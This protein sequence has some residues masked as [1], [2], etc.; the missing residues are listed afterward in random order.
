MAERGRGRGGAHVDPR[1]EAEDYRRGRGGYAERGG[2]DRGRGGGA[3]VEP[4]AQLHIETI[5][6]TQLP[7]QKVDAVIPHLFGGLRSQAEKATRP[8]TAEEAAARRK[9]RDSDAQGTETAMRDVQA[10]ASDGARNVKIPTNYFP[11][12]CSLKTSFMVYDVVVEPEIVNPRARREIVKALVAR[13]ATA[14]NVPSGIYRN[15]IMYAPRSLHP[16]NTKSVEIVHH[17]QEGAKGWKGKAVKVKLTHTRDIAATKEGLSTEY[18]NVI[19]SILAEALEEGGLMKII[20]AYYDINSQFTAAGG[21][22]QSDQYGTLQLMKGYEFALHPTKHGLM[23]NVDMTFRTTRSCTVLDHIKKIMTLEKDPKKAQKLVAEE[24]EGCIGLTTYQHERR[25]QTFKITQVLFDKTPLS[26][27]PKMTPP[28]TFKEY[29][30]SAHQIQLTDD[31]QPLLRHVSK[32][33]VDQD[34]KPREFFFIPELSRLV[35]Q[36]TRMRADADLQQELKRHCLV[37]SCTRFNVIFDFVKNFF[38]AKPVRDFLNI[39]GIVITPKM[40]LAPARVLPKVQLQIQGDRPLEQNEAR[41]SWLIRKGIRPTEL[42]AKPS[43]WAYVFPMNLKEAAQQ[44]LEVLMSDTINGVG[45]AWSA[46]TEYP[47]QSSPNPTQNL[48]TLKDRILPEIDEQTKFM[49]IVLPDDNEEFYVEVKRTSLQEW[50]IPSQCVLRKNVLNTRNHQNVASRIGGQMLV[51]AGGHLWHAAA[52]QPGVPADPSEC[53]VCGIDYATSTK[54]E[55]VALSAMAAPK[56]LCV[57][58]FSA[59]A[60]GGAVGALLR[61]AIDAYTGQF[62]KPPK[63][64]VI[65]RSGLHE[66][67]IVKIISNEVQMVTGALKKEGIT[68][69]FVASLK[70]SH[71]RFHQPP[72]GTVV[73]T[74]VTGAYGFSFLMVPQTVNIGTATAMKFSI[75]VNTV[76]ELRN[77]AV[78]EWMTFKL[79]H[80]F[81]GWWATTREP[82]PVMYASR[83]ADLASMLDLRKPVGGGPKGY[84]VF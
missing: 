44:F 62:K 54:G 40:V 63:S 49:L 30:H 4:T 9:Q 69:C 3:R 70:R 13:Q 38:Q 82:A 11:V 60:K 12:T 47:Y 16:A 14:L 55:V 72:S 80:M 77:A 58:N 7:A 45:A 79:C 28:K 75:L 15:K 8:A 48:R 66:G 23:L 84:Q 76:P 50:K 5:D 59:V 73:D 61:Q 41:R 78:L 64:V 22:I 67:D 65:F 83:L 19:T 53:M 33:E 17:A 27:I 43:T 34:G 37:D 81:Y 36:S 51:K 6:A 56:Y 39:W 71:A 29:M 46:P 35:G 10:T 1:G 20:N 26:Q 74:H 21:H 32:R 24:L 52:S 31:R 25:R 42:P 57:G 2:G 18:Y 68:C